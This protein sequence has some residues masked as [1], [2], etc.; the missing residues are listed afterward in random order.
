MHETNFWA[1]PP[2]PKSNESLQMPLG[3]QRMS[4][5]TPHGAC[6]HAGDNTINRSVHVSV[7][8]FR[9]GCVWVGAWVHVWKSRDVPIR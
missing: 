5:N 2:P 8:V 4:S 1:S 3:P 9:H 7:H 6:K